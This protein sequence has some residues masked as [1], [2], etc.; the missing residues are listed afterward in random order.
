MQTVAVRMRRFAIAWE[1]PFPTDCL[2]DIVAAL[3]ALVVAGDTAEVAYKVRVR[4][5][6]LLAKEP[7]LRREIARNLAEAYAYRSRVAHSGFVFDNVQELEMARKMKRAKGKRGNPYHDVNECNPKGFERLSDSCPF[8]E[9]Q[10]ASEDPLAQQPRPRGRLL[11][12]LTCPFTT[13]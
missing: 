9:S 3:E 1:N 4:T 7:G 10:L 12:A 11:T 6:F 13:A 5:A 8:G 2:A